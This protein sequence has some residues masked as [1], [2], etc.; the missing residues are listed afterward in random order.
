MGSELALKSEPAP[1]VACTISRDVQKFDLLIDDME[2]E[3][4]EAWGDLQLTEAKA[5]FA[6]PEASDLE[7]IAIAVDAEDEGDIG[8]IGE[9]I[10]NAI[11][12]KIKVILI[13]DDVSTAGLHQLLK[14]GAHDFVPYPLPER[15]LHEAIERIRHAEPEPVAASE[16]APATAG[17]K[18]SAPAAVFAVQKLAGGSGAT[19]L[20]VN[21][22]YEFAVL[23]KEPPSVCILDLDLQTGSVA[24]FLD[25]PRREAITEIL[26]DATSLDDESFRQAL[27]GYQD[28]LSVLTAPAEIVPLDIVGPEEIEAILEL[29]KTSFDIVIIDMPSAVVQW[30][31]TILA[32]ADVFFAVMELDMRS[33]QNAMRFIK[34]L[35]SEDLPLDKVNFVLNRAPKMTDLNGKG[36]VKRLSESLGVKISTQLSDGG[37]QVTEA[38]DH[39]GPLAEI[40]KKNATRKDV[41]KLAQSLHDAMLGDGVQAM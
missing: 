29:A 24:T 5:F 21:L 17:Q 34:A 6:Q 36:R 31:E 1:L 18:M 33:A 4:G 7:F 23:D 8:L 10:G 25:L 15:A 14:L 40:A 27:L 16:Q 35:Q 13:A 22:A 2:A 26:T 11:G 32:R 30:T 19:T 39:G 12:R 9:I 41:V 28:K 3:L 38:C 37:K 20:A